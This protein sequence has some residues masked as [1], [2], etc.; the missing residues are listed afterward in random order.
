MRMRNSII[1]YLCWVMFV[2]ICPW[3]D[4]Q[5][6]TLRPSD[7]SKYQKLHRDVA[8]SPDG[9]FAAYV[10][11]RSKESALGAGLREWDENQRNDVW[12][13]DLSTG[14]SEKI[15]NGRKTGCG[16]WMPRWSPDGR[17]VAM[18]ST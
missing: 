6:P 11:E 2:L 18:L 16:Y 13:A 8:L 14:H 10:V 7:L 9:R 4:A 12:I 1:S 15:T 5:S 17:R 3:A